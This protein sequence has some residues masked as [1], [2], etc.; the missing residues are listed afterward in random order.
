MRHKYGTSYPLIILY[1][2]P[3]LPTLTL[4]PPRYPTTGLAGVSEP[5]R[6][7]QT[8]GAAGPARLSFSA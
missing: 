4:H 5:A 6:A 8:I 7:R 2:Y 1:Y 3:I